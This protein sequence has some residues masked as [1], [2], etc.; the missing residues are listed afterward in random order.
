LLAFGVASVA[1]L[2][3][4][5]SNLIGKLFTGGTD[6]LVALAQ[7]M[8]DVANKLNEFDW[9]SAKHPTKAYAEGVGG[10]LLAFA[11]VFAKISRVEGFNK[12]V[13]KL[14]SG[15][16]DN[17]TT[18][19]DNAAK[20]MLK[21]HDQLNIDW[22]SAKYPSKEYAEGV[23][24]F[25]ESLANVF[26]SISKVEGFNK[27]VTKLFGGGS[28]NFTTFI[29]NAAKAMLKVHDQLNIDWTNA[30]HPS[31]EYAEGVGGFLESLANAFASISKVNGFNSLFGNETTFS[32]FVENAAQS[33]VTAN[34]ILNEVNWTSSN[35][36]SKEY[37]E[38]IGSFLISMA[39]AYSKIN[40]KGFLSTIGELFGGGN[41]Q[42]LKEFVI[43]ASNS[44]VEASKILAD[45]N[46]S[47]I[48]DKAYIDGFTDTMIGMSKITKSIKNL[49]IKDNFSSFSIN[50]ATTISN[51]SKA[52]GEGNY[53]NIPN[54]KYTESFSKFVITYGE[55]AKSDYNIED[56]NKF[57]KSIEVI[58]SSVNKLNQ[59][60]DIKD[61]MTNNMKKIS[62]S[63][64]ELGIGVDNFMHETP[65]GILGKGIRAVIGKKKRDMTEFSNFST[66]LMTLVSALQILSNLQ[67]MP[68]GI[69]SGYQSFLTEFSKLPDLTSLDPKIESIN[70]L[71]NSFASLAAS[72]TQVNSNLDG[73]TNLSKGLFLIS[74]IDDTK[75]DNVLKSVDKY[76][77]TLQ[78]INDVPSE[79]ANLLA[80]IKGL[81]ET[82]SNKPDTSVN[83]NKVV[84]DDK[85]LEI[86]K[87]QQFY[88][89]VAYIRNI[90]EN[91]KDEMAKPSQQ[92]S[93]WI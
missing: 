31:K 5:A 91:I 55:L 56:F 93:P 50:A 61:T 16:S 89:D 85:T 36:P 35:Y 29:D 18:F 34:S 88:D 8:V 66:A 62:E 77:T 30:K 52:L 3:A 40:S 41:K 28:D 46:F 63:L 81:Y 80:T 90:L 42:S 19:I 44:L 2:A 72:L 59:M 57:D 38:G 76:K 45:G 24:G 22:A 20:A 73:F 14:F 84:V 68:T 51:A 13:N 74:V 25:L 58:I 70:K 78:L 82:V 47:N 4:G 7:R 67:P 27:I 65:S 21:V 32:A 48:I 71:S 17:F 11:N 10:L 75:F 92:S 9:T 49:E 79:Q 43:E 15:G 12:I 26:A 86:N 87:K 69:M 33:M 23:G 6:P 39:D 64:T 53:T 83:E 60:P 37:S 1:A 54:K